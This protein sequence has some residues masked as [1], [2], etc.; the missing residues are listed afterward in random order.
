VGVA[1]LFKYQAAAWGPA[2]AIAVIL[3]GWRDGKARVLGRLVLLA[4]GG[5]LPPL[6]AWAVF[7]GLGAGDDF[8]YW[9]WTHNVAY[10]TN[11]ASAGETAERAAAYLLPFLLATLP[12]WWAAWRSRRA[13]GTYAAA[14]VAALLALSVVAALPG[15]RLYPHYLIPLYFPL[16]LGAAPWAAEHV[17]RPLSGPAQGFVAWAAVLL[18]GFTA[19]N[20]YVYGVRDDVYTETHPAISRVAARLRDDRCF[21]E[22]PLF[23]W[24]WAPMF[25]TATRLP[26][27]SRFLLVG[28]SLVGYVSANRDP[29]AGDGLVSAQHWDWLLEDLAR[30][31]PTYV[32]DTAGARL[33]RWGFPLEERRLLA[34]FVAASYEPLDVVD[35]VRI[36]RRRGCGAP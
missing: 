18:A 34:A 36:Y 11:L 22:G 16:A 29:G 14:L 24:G 5:L 23:V 3:A 17:R 20:A 33:G 10:A 4:T 28:F 9:N 15:L 35:H 13:L 30:R 2:L 25:Y 19:A 6:A 12:L 27:A 7:A 32:L 31:R 8:V 1:T 26:P 21:G